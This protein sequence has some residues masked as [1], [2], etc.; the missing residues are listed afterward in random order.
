MV[1]CAYVQYGPVRVLLQ[2]QV[3]SKSLSILCSTNC[4]MRSFRL[5]VISFGR[6][7]TYMKAQKKAFIGFIAGIA[8]W[9]NCLF[10]GPMRH[11]FFAWAPA[12]L[13]AKLAM[14]WALWHLALVVVCVC[15]GGGGA[16]STVACEMRR[17]KKE[18]QYYQI[19]SDL[20]HTNLDC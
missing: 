15:V 17:K 8:W 13:F 16:F 6:A 11:V 14:R 9:R 10:A 20:V 1:A 3:S 18:N 19:F 5:R 7:S 2:N 4:T 12:M